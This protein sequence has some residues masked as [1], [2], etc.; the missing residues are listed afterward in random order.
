MHLE[1]SSGGY[2]YI[3]VIADHFTRFAQAYPT[4]NKSSITAAKNCTMTLYFGLVFQEKF[5]TT[6]E[7]NSKISYFISSRN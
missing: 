6:K 5:Y 1:K 7:R 3:L 4:K 2:E